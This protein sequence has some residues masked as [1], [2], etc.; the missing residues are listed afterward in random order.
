MTDTTVQLYADWG[1][2]EKTINPEIYLACGYTNI[3][4]TRGSR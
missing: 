3:V 1:G 2:E 4:L